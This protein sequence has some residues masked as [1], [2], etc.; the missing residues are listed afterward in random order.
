MLKETSL[1]SINIIKALDIYRDSN[2][3]GSTTDLHHASFKNMCMYI[4][5]YIY[6]FIFIF[7]FIWVHTTGNRRLT[8]FPVRLEW[9]NFVESF[10]CG[11]VESQALF[12]LVNRETEKSLAIRQITNGKIQHVVMIFFDRIEDANNMI[13]AK[14]TWCLIND[15]QYIMMKLLCSW[16][17]WYCYPRNAFSKPRSPRVLWTCLVWTLAATTGKV[18]GEICSRPSWMSWMWWIPYQNWSKIS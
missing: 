1:K 10:W 15:N 16:W 7:I 4:I 17:Q 13:H 11:I 18:E 3:I 6:I 2:Q 12:L 14:C 8:V 9:D 5:W